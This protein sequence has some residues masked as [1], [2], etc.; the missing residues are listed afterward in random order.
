MLDS[1]EIDRTCL[2]YILWNLSNLYY[3]LRLS[4]SM[5]RYILETIEELLEGV[6]EDVENPDA[7]YKLRTARQLLNV[8]DQRNEE[9]SVAVNEAASEDELR[10]RLRDLGYL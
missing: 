10:K 2:Q 4:Y 5:T 6:Q 9:L 7:S 1:P 8:L 3:I